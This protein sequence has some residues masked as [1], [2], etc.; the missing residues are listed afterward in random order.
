MKTFIGKLGDYYYNED[1]YEHM[2]LLVLFASTLSLLIMIL[3][4][5]GDAL[6]GLINLYEGIT[7]Y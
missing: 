7:R 2:L 4:P 3:K 5:G 1:F 6:V